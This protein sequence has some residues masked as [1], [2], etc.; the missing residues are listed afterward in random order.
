MTQREARETIQTQ[1]RKAVDRNVSF[2]AFDQ[3]LAEGHLQ[4]AR[5]CDRSHEIISERLWSAFSFDW[6]KVFFNPGGTVGKASAFLQAK[7]DLSYVW[8]LA[9][10]E[11]TEAVRELEATLLEDLHLL[12]VEWAGY[13]LTSAPELEVA[14][15]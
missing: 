6:S 9:G 12:W 1:F 3:L 8:S 14:L 13:S 11:F 7:A 10:G 2:L 4:A 5:L 15:D